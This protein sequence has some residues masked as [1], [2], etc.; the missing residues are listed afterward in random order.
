VHKI[1]RILAS[2]RHPF[3]SLFSGPFLSGSSEEGSGC[4]GDGT[5]FATGVPLWYNGRQIQGGGVALMQWDWKGENRTVDSWESFAARE[6]GASRWGRLNNMSRA[7]LFLAA[8]LLVPLAASAQDDLPCLRCHKSKGA[9]KIVH[10]AVQM[11]C[12]SCHLSPHEEEAPSLALSQDV[13]DLCFGCHDAAAFEGVSQHPPVTAGMCYNCHEPHSTDQDGLLTKEIPTLC[14]I[15]H[16]EGMFSKEILHPPTAMG[17]CGTCHAAHASD[18]VAHLSMT[19]PETCAGCHPDKGSGRHVFAGL[20][21]GGT[22]PVSGMLDPSRAGRQLSCTS[23]HDPHSSTKK[24]LFTNEEDGVESLCWLCHRKIT[25]EP[26][27]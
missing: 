2:T 5:L 4:E 10:P 14:F 22:H 23:C 27:R 1:A 25:V 8:L 21:L 20:G 17:G 9:G 3:N 13:P 7:L 11:G 26:G 12:S 18:H 19:I 6:V 15:C 24:T 16:D